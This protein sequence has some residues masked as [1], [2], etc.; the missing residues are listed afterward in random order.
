MSPLKEHSQRNQWKTRESD[1]MFSQR[2]K[3]SVDFSAFRPGSSDEERQA[4]RS[5]YQDVRVCDVNS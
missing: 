5:D 1:P 3:D 2:T 4:N